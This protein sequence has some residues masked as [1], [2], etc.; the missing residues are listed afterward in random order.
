[1][2]RIIK[3]TMVEDAPSNVSGAIATPDSQI[4]SPKP[5]KKRSGKK[6]KSLEVDNSES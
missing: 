5:D 2:K 1:M 4:L 3:L 6:E